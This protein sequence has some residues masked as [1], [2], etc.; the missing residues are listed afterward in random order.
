[1]NV[2]S[3]CI[4]KCKLNEDQKLCEGCFRT[5][6]EISNWNVYSDNQKKLVLKSLKSRKA[7]ILF[8]IIFLFFN[9]CISSDLWVGKWMAQD[10]WQSEFLIEIR[11]DGTAESDYGNGQTGE[12]SIVDGNLEIIWKSG[13]KDY[14]F[15]GVMGYQ[16]LS[17]NNDSSYTSGLRKLLD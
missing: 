11:D 15:S 12:W 4:D 1:M 17:K 7:Q 10:Q 13:K 5:P 14:L 3:P 2:K 8:L 9:D 6:D 16:R